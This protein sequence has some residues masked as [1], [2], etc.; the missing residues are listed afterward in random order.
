MMLQPF[1]KQILTKGEI[2]LILFGGK[3]SHSILKK[4]K[5]GDFRVQD[6]FGGTVHNHTASA[7]E[8]EYAESVISAC[9]TMPLYA[10][11]D[12]IFDNDDQLSL[13]ELEIIEPELWLRKIPIAV[14][15][16]ADALLERLD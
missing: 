14:D 5:A 16:F 4:V 3:Y 12:V 11:V 1:Q 9:T 2:S 6:D 13:L 15:R 10:R 7:A 8:I